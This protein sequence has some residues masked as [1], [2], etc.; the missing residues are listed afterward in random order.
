MAHRAIG[1]ALTQFGAG[2]AQGQE[3]QANRIIKQQEFQL[4]KQEFG[5]RKQAFEQNRLINEERLLAA[6]D[7]REQRQNKVAARARILKNFNT[8]ATRGATTITEQFPIETEGFAP[9]PTAIEQEPFV[10]PDFGGVEYRAD[11]SGD[12]APEQTDFFQRRRGIDLGH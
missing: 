4:R 5:L 9:A 3:R 2:F 7:E 12:A 8:L 11:A 10:S 1:R 6:Q